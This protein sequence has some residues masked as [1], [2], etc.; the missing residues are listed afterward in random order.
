MVIVPGLHGRGAGHDGRGRREERGW[1]AE[2]QIRQRQRVRAV[3]LDLLVGQLAEVHPLEALLWVGNL[4]L[5]STSQHKEG[6][7]GLHLRSRCTTTKH[8]HASAW[9]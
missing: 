8:A 6:C 2:R 4:D 7:P 9:A 5:S 3:R 1:W